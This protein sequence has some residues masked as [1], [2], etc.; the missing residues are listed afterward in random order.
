[1]K[2]YDPRLWIG[3]LLIFGGLLAMLQNLDIISS[4]GGIF[5]GVIWGAVGLYFL[6]RLIIQ[7]EWWAV[8]PAFVFLSWAVSSFLP[9]P[10]DAFGGLVFFAG[11][12]LAFLWLYFT[13]RSRWW[14]IIPAGVMLT[15][16]TVS[17]V[18]R[19]GD[20]NGGGLFFLGLGLTFILVAI[21]PGG[22]SRSWALIPGTILLLFGAALG[23][24]L[25]GFTQYFTPAALILVG[26]YLLFRFFRGQSSM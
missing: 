9:D 15:I 6:Q 20:A 22:G 10:L 23:T 5:W 8:F 19:V 3:G 16:G 14:A 17:V 24:P 2:R 7:R 26:G 4:V 1:M 11:L 25:R 13:D 21:L 12:S 18:D